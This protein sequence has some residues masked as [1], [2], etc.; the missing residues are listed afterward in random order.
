MILDKLNKLDPSESHGPDLLHPR[1]LFE[2]RQ[3]TAYLLKLM[4]ERSLIDHEL[5]CDWKCST[6]TAIHKRFKVRRYKLQTS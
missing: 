3:E 2:V 6:V 5:P 4:F 1:M